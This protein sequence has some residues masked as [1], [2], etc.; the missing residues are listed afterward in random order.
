MSLLLEAKAICQGCGAAMPS[1]LA[2]SV[3][4]DRRPDLRDDIMAGAFQAEICP[5]CGAK[6]RFPL[7]LSYIDNLRGQWILAEGAEAA[8]NWRNIETE[9]RLI[10]NDAHGPGSPLVARELGRGLVPRVV[11]GWASLREKLLVREL[12]LDDLTLELLKMVILREIPDPPLADQNELRLTG[13]DEEQLHLAWIESAS[14]T[15]LLGLSVPREAYT[16]IETDSVPW[17]ALRQSFADA[18]FVDFRRLFLSDPG[19]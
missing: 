17:L 13:A 18:Y 8:P 3:N 12:N 19:N 10:F 16:A 14:E 2:A 15:E 9:A 1:R 6:L 7:H 4:A 5:G 11:F